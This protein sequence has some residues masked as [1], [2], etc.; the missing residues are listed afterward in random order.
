MFLEHVNLSV[1]DVDRS[2][3]FYEA[4]LGLRVRWRGRT[5]TGRRAV[6]VGNERAYL[7]LFE[8]ESSE[9]APAIDYERAGFNHLG[10]VVP[11]LARAR[12]ALVAL[13]I[14]PHFEHADPPGQRLYF[15]D[16]DGLEVELVQYASPEEALAVRG[17]AS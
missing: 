15:L 5:S 3:R 4:L 12:A 7:A 6:H 8:A 11:D 1:A 16:P 13:G 2:A 10:W 17:E 9:P 14:E